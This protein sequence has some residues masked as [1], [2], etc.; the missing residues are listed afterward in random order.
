MTE[1]MQALRPIDFAVFTTTFLFGIG[2]LSLFLR[3]YGKEEDV[4]PAEKAVVDDFYD[5]W[6]STGPV[7]ARLIEGYDKLRLVPHE[8]DYTYHILFSGTRHRND[9]KV[10]LTLRVNRFIDGQVGFA[11]KVLSTC[12]REGESVT[13]SLTESEVML[14]FLRE[15]LQNPGFTTNDGGVGVV[16]ERS[17]SATK[18]YN[19]DRDIRRLCIAAK[20]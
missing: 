19:R 1:L 16:N 14:A 5:I 20:N 17:T 13:F 9:E 15:W 10:F 12:G 4:S 2:I 6:A 3:K 8:Q 18:L 11:I 7:L